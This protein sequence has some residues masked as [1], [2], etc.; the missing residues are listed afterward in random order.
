MYLSNFHTKL[1]HCKS[2]VRQG[3]SNYDFSQENPSLAPLTPNT[4]DLPMITT[5]S[6]TSILNSCRFQL[7]G[8]ELSA[9]PSLPPPTNNGFGPVQWQVRIRGVVWPEVRYPPPIRY[10]AP[11]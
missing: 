4:Q 8:S 5:M 3:G 11:R 1:L 10:G 2:L 7:K 6:L 9:T